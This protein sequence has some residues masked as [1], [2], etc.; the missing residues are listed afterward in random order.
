MQIL[1]VGAG[2]VGCYIG[3]QLARAGHAVTLLGRDRVTRPIRDNGLTIRSVAVGQPSGEVV[4]AD[5]LTASSLTDALKSNPGFDLAVFTMKAY[6]TA[7]AVQ[8]W[9]LANGPSIPI[10]CMQNGI[11]SEEVIEELLGPGIAVAGTMTTAVSMDPPGVVT[12]ETQRGIALASDS[13]AYPAAVMAFQSLQ[14][15]VQTVGTT[16]S[17]KWSK[18]LLNMIGNATSAILDMPPA[19]IMRDR[20]L[21]SVEVQALKEALSIMTLLDIPVC[22]LPGAPA[23]VLA[24]LIRT[25]PLA[26][27]QPLLR[28][29]FTSARGDKLPSLAVALRNHDRRTEVAWLNGAVAQS[30]RTLNRRTPINHALALLVSDI[31]S[32]RVPWEMVRHK[33]E[34]LLAA[35]RAAQG[36]S[37]W[38][39]GE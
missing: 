17:L 7:A 34:I 15:K 18:L 35:M 27:L 25:L 29:R 24:G 11:G 22:N 31:A 19:E 30:A 23:A 38:R 6:D 36:N 20:D 21:F 14:I 8:E 12:E 37:R 13:A 16:A 10:V 9:Q 3:G 1:V 4:L 26:I 32:E 5:I 28:A 33:P 39:Y 2:A